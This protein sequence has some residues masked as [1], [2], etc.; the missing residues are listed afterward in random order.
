MTL[1]AHSAHPPALTDRQQ[2]D[3]DRASLEKLLWMTRAQLQY[4]RPR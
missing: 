4:G 1:T 2:Q 3:E